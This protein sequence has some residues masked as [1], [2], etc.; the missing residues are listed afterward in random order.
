MAGAA[1]VAE[2]PQPT[3]VA[4]DFGHLLRARP[5]S[6]L[7]LGA[8]AGRGRAR[9]LHQDRYDFNDALLPVGASWFA[10]L[11]ERLLPRG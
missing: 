10:L 11:A 8:W 1:R 6:F 3:M 7:L 5:G 2:L 4:E 9:G